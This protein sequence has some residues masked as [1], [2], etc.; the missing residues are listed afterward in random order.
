M[1]PHAGAHKRNVL[2]FAPRLCEPEK[3][4]HPGL[5]ER[6]RANDQIERLLAEELLCLLHAFR[7]SELVARK[8]AFKDLTRL[9]CRRN[10]DLGYT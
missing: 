9:R 6:N 4:E 5:V 8:N 10:Q 3:I 1:G 7:A 2:P